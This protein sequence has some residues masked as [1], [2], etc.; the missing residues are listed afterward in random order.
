MLLAAVP[1]VVASAGLAVLNRKFVEPL[2][3]KVREVGL[4]APSVADNGARLTAL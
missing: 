1:I 2:R 4:Q 3:G